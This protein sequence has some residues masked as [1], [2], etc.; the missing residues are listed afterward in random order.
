MRKTYIGNRVKEKT[1]TQNH[2]LPTVWIFKLILYLIRLKDKCIISWC[3]KI[4]LFLFLN[5]LYPNGTRNEYRKS[6]SELIPG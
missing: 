2:S 1:K 3:M 5:V 4:N 6:N